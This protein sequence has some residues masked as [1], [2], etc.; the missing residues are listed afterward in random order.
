MRVGFVT[1][2][3]WDRYGP[4]WR[5]L[6]EGSGAEPLFPEPEAV[7]EA[8][9]AL[10]EDAAPSA[11]FRLALA[12]AAA[13]DEADLLVLPRLNPEGAG[14]RGAGSDRWI[15]DLPGALVSALPSGARHVAVAAYPD[16]AVESDAVTLLTELVRGA[17]EVGRVWA[18]FRVKAQHLAEGRAE[19]NRAR[20]ADR[21]A[22]RSF[23]H[24]NAVVYL[25]Q[26]WVMTPEVARRLQERDDRVVTQLAVDPA[27]AREE[28]WRFDE[29]LVHTDAEVLGAARLLSRRAGALE[30]RL[31]VD[32]G[33]DSDAW[34]AR[35][36]EQV[37]RRPFTA[38]PW[39][40]ALGVEDP[41][42]ALH[43]LPVD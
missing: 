35:R 1:Q 23:A 32:E 2:L 38:Q 40:E 42:D 24:G 27:K 12:Q 41:F 9:A 11:S 26:P 21:A 6:A 13:L 31:I 18:R 5:D 19:T 28:G 30:V 33:S 43:A 16:P 37:V 25:A 36:I 8:L 22:A 10:P 34:L 3:L 15:A 14:A 17:A 7:R 29:R 4:F 20:G 39:Q